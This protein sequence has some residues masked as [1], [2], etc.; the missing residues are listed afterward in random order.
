VLSVAATAGLLISAPGWRDRLLVLHHM[1]TWIATSAAYTAAAE[2]YCEPLLVTFTGAL[3]LYSV[4]AN[5]LAV[6]AAPPATVLGVA[7][8]A[9]FALWTPAGHAAAWLA[10]W[11]TRW[12]CLVAHQ[13]AHVPGASLPWPNGL[14][15]MFALLGA[16]AI[17][18]RLSRALHRIREQHVHGQLIHEQPHPP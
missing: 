11:P 3:P 5:V 1:P 2:I 17:G 13:V 18:R 6:P 10:Q 4:A 16:Y 7:A 12:I 15:G 8:M 14:T 9:G